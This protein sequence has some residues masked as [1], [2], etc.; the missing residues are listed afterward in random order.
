MATFENIVFLFQNYGVLDFLI[1]FLL[2]FAVTFAI[3]QKSKILGDKANIHFIIAFTFGMLFV[4]PHVLGRYPPQYDP[5]LVLNSAIPSISLVSIAAVAVLVLLGVF[6]KRFSKTAAPVIAILSILAVIFIFGSALGLWVA[7]N[8]LF[9]W[10]TADDFEWLVVILVFGVLV[11]L[12]TMPQRNKEKK[13][14]G[15]LKDFLGGLTE[16]TN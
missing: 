11:F 3:L 8:D 9:Y 5:V 7:P 16:D 13:A 14:G 1:P 15:A 10:W 12:I 6:G 4:V 2:V